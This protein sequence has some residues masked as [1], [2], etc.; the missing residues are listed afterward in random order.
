MRA[1]RIPSL[2]LDIFDIPP[3]VSI[4][5]MN[6]KYVTTWATDIYAPSVVRKRNISSLGENERWLLIENPI[7]YLVDFVR[8]CVSSS[9]WP[10]VIIPWNN[11]KFT[12]KEDP[13]AGMY[14]TY[15]MSWQWIRRGKVGTCWV[16]VCCTNVIRVGDKLNVEVWSTI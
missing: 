5:P 1:R 10:W 7:S 14:P 11:N 9:P 3:H 15:S 6:K 12:K 2:W 13:V 4:K 16:Y 8:P